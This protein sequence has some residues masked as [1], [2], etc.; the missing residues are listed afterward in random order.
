[1]RIRD[2]H[3]EQFGPLRD[4]RMDNLPDGLTVVLGRNEAGKS[5]LLDFFRAGLREA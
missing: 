5:T 4:A 3:V 1:M 2:A